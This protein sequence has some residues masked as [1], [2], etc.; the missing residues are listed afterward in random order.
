M[1]IAGNEENVKGITREQLIEKHRKIYTPENSILCV[2]G[3]NNFSEILSLAKKLCVNRVGEKI[4]IPKIEKQNIKENEKREG[5]SQANLAIG[6]H[7]P[8]LDEKERYPAEVFSAILGEGMSSKLF[9][10]VREKRGLV[11]SVKTEIDAGKNYSYL[12]IWAGTEPGKVPGVI[13]ICLE[14]FAKMGKIT[15]KELEEAKV[16]VIG[17]QKL[18]LAS[19]T[20]RGLVQNTKAAAV[21]IFPKIKRFPLLKNRLKNYTMSLVKPNGWLG[22]MTQLIDLV[23]NFPEW[24]YI[25]DRTHVSFFS[26]Q[27]FRYLAKQDGLSVEFINNNVILMQKQ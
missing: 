19:Y 9:I 24:Y 13:E 14:E 5:I 11:Y 21:R 20:D 1:F 26:R 23:E 7:F 18:K 27:T 8:K 25:K 15:E 16:Q 6:F 17:N 4:T 2:V 10:E 22:F 12:M 3:N